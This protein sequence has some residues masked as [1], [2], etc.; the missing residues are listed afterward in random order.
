MLKRINGRSAPAFVQYCT[1][2]VISQSSK[3][4]STSI[5][6]EESHTPKRGMMQLTWASAYES[7]GN[8]RNFKN[9]STGHYVDPRITSTSLHHWNPP[10]IVHGV[11]HTDTR[12]WSQRYDPDILATNGYNICD[13]ACFFG[14]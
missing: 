8:F 14:N 6:T 11:E 3:A 4:G 7:Y 10:T 9:N 13:S 12:Q 1:A 2:N 5:M